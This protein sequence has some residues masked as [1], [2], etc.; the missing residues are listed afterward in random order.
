MFS[1]RF[2]A[3]PS[4]LLALSLAS[5]PLVAQQG[6]RDGEWR[7][8]GGDSGTTKYSPLDQINEENVAELEIV[9]R[10]KADNFGPRPDNNWQATPVMANGVLYTTAGM[11][12][13]AVA[14][15][16]AT[17][18]TLWMFRFDEGVR[19]DRAPRR[20]NRGLT[21]WTDGQ[22]ERIFMI[23]LG[24]QLIALDAKTGH[25][26]EN[27]GEKGVVDL[28]LGLDRDE[29]EPGRIGSS[30]PAIV[31]NDVIVMGAALQSGG[32]P[33]S[34]TNVPGYIRGFDVRTGKKLWTF[35]TIPHEG[36]FGNDTWGDRSWE[37]TGNVGAWPAL[38]GDEE[39]GYVYIPLEAPTGDFY[40]GHRPGDNLF[41]DSVVCLDAKTG[42]RVW[43]FQAVHHDVWDYDFGS[44]PILADVTVDGRPRKIVAQPSKQG[45]LYVLDR[46][47]GEPIWPIEERPVP[48]SNVPGEKTAATQPFPTKPAPFEMQGSMDENLLDLTPELKAEAIEIAREYKQGPLFEPPIERD[49]GGKLALIMVPNAQGAA[50]WEGG[51]LDP[52]TGIV[53]IAS[54]NRE[55]F[56][57]LSRPQPDRSDMDFVS[58]GGARRRPAPAAAEARPGRTNNGP[59]GLPLLRPPWGRITAIDLNTGDHVWMKPN[60]DAPEFIKNHPALKGIDLSG[61]GNPDQATLM[62]TKTLLFGGVGGGMFNAGPDGGSPMFR[63]MNKA[64]GELIHEMEL[65]AGTTS[66]PM[67]YMVNGRQYIVV[68][69]GSPEHNAE[70]IALAV[71]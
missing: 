25:L 17:G 33:D 49:S 36:E 23:S 62:V 44:P 54:T 59:Q 69:V 19:G 66:I 2:P 41:S 64:T 9:W 53:Y 28:T 35:R 40:G 24:Y 13:D 50:N 37:Y 39:L 63:V 32:A 21:Y 65:P 5:S 70:L 20:N 60:G 7:F 1:K 58:G 67:T 16:A 47:S 48:Q 4:L 14:I 22:E 11:R 3:F 68:A 52:E 18:E 6:A 51:A 31:I 30:S 46:V 26:I 12:R 29:V 38:S 15:D 27:F 8:Y 71:P 10:W 42:E 56:I 34:K 55:S 57:G 61:V 43:H 45:F